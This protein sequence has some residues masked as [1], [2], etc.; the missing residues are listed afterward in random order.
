MN[1]NM[2]RTPFSTGLSGSAKETEI[3]IRNIFSG[4]KRRPPVP[5][6]VL[7]VLLILF[8]G[9]IVS[10]QMAETEAPEPGV[11]SSLVDLPDPPEQKPV[12]EVREDSET[13]ENVDLDGDGLAD[14]VT[15]VVR[16][17]PQDENGSTITLTAVLGRGETLER[18]WTEEEYYLS[19]DSFSAGNITS[20]DRDALTLDAPVMLARPSLA[21]SSLRRSTW[22]GTWGKYAWNHAEWI[23]IH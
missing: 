20:P 11:N 2:P 21:V 18:Q 14:T 4:P 5:V 15:A 12:A 13:L 3:R 9:N 7:T 1:N 10:C 22:T 19:I 17:D 6:M 23:D 16:F 8:C